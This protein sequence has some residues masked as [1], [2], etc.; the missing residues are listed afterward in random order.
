VL[1]INAT[2]EKSIVDIIV[3]NYSGILLSLRGNKDLKNVSSRI[4]R[5]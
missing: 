5:R 4:R 2:K 1:V 3:E